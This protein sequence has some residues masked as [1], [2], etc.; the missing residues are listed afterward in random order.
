MSDIPHTTVMSIWRKCGSRGLS[1]IGLRVLVLVA[2]GYIVVKVAGPRP[3][4]H[5]A[6]HQHSKPAK[7]QERRDV[8]AD[9]VPIEAENKAWTYPVHLDLDLPAKYRDDPILK[10]HSKMMRQYGFNLA[11]SNSLPLYRELEDRRSPSCK[12]IQYPKDMPKTSVIIIFYNEALSTLLRNIVSVLNRSPEHLLG[13]IVLVDDNST[14][15]EL[16]ELPRHLAKL[17]PKVTHVCP[18]ASREAHSPI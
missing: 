16:E 18:L 7:P 5:A 4:D 11:K 8:V 3:A 15:A 9:E 17:P 14:L 13:E 6:I 2:L 12:S 1:G 10:D